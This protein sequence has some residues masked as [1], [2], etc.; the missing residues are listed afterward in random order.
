M[1]EFS[2]ASVVLSYFLVAGGLFT[3]ML[4]T[5]LLGIQSEI[6]GYVLLGAGA[7]VGGF[8]AARA[9][10]GSTIVE[11]AIGAVAVVGTVVALAATTDLGQVLWAAARNETVKL[12]AGVGLT[13]MVGAILGA[14][15]SERAFGE[16]TESSLPWIIYTA[17]STFGA[18]LLALL[19]VGVV[20]KSDSSNYTTG[21]AGIAAV[22]SGCLLAGVSVGASART[23]PLAAA[24]L[25]GG[26]GVA[27]FFFLIYR[28]IGG[29]AAHD[30]TQDIVAGLA[31]LGGGGAIVTFLGA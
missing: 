14:F 27:G 1:N 9:S 19:I 2:F 5:S 13:S 10:R 25:G 18:S 15:I 6:A 3:G 26:I 7:F 17:F 30:R 8:V 12:V 31:V 29:A 20:I 21:V 24:F 23:R 22:A 16:A 4:V 28:M 11:P